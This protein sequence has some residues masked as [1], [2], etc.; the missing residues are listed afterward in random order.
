MLVAGLQDLLKHRPDI[1]GSSMDFF[2]HHIH[3]HDWFSSVF[4]LFRGCIH[5]SDRPPRLV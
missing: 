5:V 3:L 2:D 4:G 1:L